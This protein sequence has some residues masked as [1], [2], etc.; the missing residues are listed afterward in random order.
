M[1][2]FYMFTYRRSLSSAEVHVQSLDFEM[3][4]GRKS[5]AFGSS[6]KFISVVFLNIVLVLQGVGLVFDSPKLKVK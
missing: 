5:C 3:K 1:I 4:G 2:S 6:F